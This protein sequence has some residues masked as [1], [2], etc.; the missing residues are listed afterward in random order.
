MTLSALLPSGNIINPSIEILLGNPRESV[1]GRV[2]RLKAVGSFACPHCF[3]HTGDRLPVLFRRGGDT[4]RDHFYHQGS[5]GDSG[6]K[7][8]TPEGEMHLTAKDAIARSLESAGLIDVALEVRIQTPGLAFAKPDILAYQPNGAMECHEVQVSPISVE[9]LQRRSDRHKEGGAAKVTW[10][11]Y[12]SNWSRAH[13]QYCQD[14]S[15]VECFHLTFHDEMPKWEKIPL[16]PRRENQNV[17]SSGVDGCG[18]RT[19][20]QGDAVVVS[21]DSWLQWAQAKRAELK[22]ELDATPS[23]KTD[24]LSFQRLCSQYKSLNSSINDFGWM[25]HAFEVASVDDVGMTIVRQLDRS[26]DSVLNSGVKKLLPVSC[27]GVLDF[28]DDA[29]RGEFFK[30]LAL[31]LKKTP[32]HTENLPRWRSLQEDASLP[33]MVGD[34]VHKTHGIA[35]MD[36]S[37]NIDGQWIRWKQGDRIPVEGWTGVIK[38]DW[39]D[40]SYLVDFGHGTEESI[41]RRNLEPWRYQTEPKGFS[42]VLVSAAAI[43][44]PAEKLDEP[45]ALINL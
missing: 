38:R 12:G 14:S 36:D 45:V 25:R 5:D 32:A 7:H 44:K 13:R 30:G 24:E 2:L 31:T 33:L 42:K 37:A 18:D 28:A 9:E 26:G 8:F 15:A 20:R 22:Q 43:E 4:R 1:V 19:A 17:G 29:S 21:A 23:H 3:A 41:E 40:H 11:L 16:A 39:G 10:Y 35:R 6:C 34:V 27:L